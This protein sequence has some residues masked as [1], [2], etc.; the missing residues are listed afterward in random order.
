[1]PVILD[2]RTGQLID[3]QTGQVV[4]EPRM[5]GEAA[6]PRSAA[7]PDA[8]HPA[9]APSSNPGGKKGNDAQPK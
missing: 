4:A 5:K 1:M 9:Q 7:N 2:P 8:N 3:V 6:N